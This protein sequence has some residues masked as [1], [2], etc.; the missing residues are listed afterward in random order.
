MF[1]GSFQEGFVVTMRWDPTTRGGMDVG[2]MWDL[3]SLEYNVRREYKVRRGLVPLA[4][5]TMVGKSTPPEN[6]FP[7]QCHQSPTLPIPRLSR[8]HQRAELS[9]YQI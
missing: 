7:S 2:W 9:H 6:E 5:K 8:Q 4:S 3:G 1:E